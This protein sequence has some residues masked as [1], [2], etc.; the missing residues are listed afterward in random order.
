MSEYWHDSRYDPLLAT[1]SL[2][3]YIY[4]YILTYIHISLYVLAVLMTLDYIT[5]DYLSFWP[6]TSNINNTHT[7]LGCMEAEETNMSPCDSQQRLIPPLALNAAEASLTGSASDPTF[8]AAQVWVTLVPI[9][10]WYHISL[11]YQSNN[12][13]EYNQVTVVEPPAQQAPNPILQ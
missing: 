6:L 9:G 12:K 13:Y 7:L 5:T 8:T 1:C 11:W 4:I 2:K 10:Y 3:L